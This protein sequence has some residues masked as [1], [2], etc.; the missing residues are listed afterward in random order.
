VF[1]NMMLRRIFGPSSEEVAV[2]WRRLKGEGK[3]VPVLLFSIE[4]H[5]MEAYWGSGCIY[6][7]ILDLGTRWR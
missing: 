5:A 6:P 4:Q 7:R 1:E 2:G 3:D